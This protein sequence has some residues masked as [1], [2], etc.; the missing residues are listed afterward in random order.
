MA[1]GGVA[2]VKFDSPNSKV[3]SLNEEV[4]TEFQHALRQLQS[5]PS[6]KSAVLCSGKTG[7][8]IAGADINMLERWVSLHTKIFYKFIE[9]NLMFKTIN[10]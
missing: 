2:I 10:L 3:N 7:C 8:F 6:V 5:D 4:M 9:V 1:D